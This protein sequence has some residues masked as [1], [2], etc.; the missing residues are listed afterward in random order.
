MAGM[1]AVDPER[2]LLVF[3]LQRRMAANGNTRILMGEKYPGVFG[4]RNRRV[5]TPFYKTVG[6]FIK[7]RLS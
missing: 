3:T 4:R 2:T 6:S 5:K 1:S 7:I